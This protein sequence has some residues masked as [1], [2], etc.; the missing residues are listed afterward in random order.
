MG[1]KNRL[2]MYSCR[3]ATRLMAEEAELN[4]FG[5]AKLKMHVFICP[6]C[7]KFQQQMIQLKLQ[8][9]KNL[10]KENTED[11]KLRMK[12]LEDNIVSKI[13]RSAD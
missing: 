6:M 1:E 12:N 11:E 4:W 10:T 13:K 3:E 8:I 5:T 2:L 9:R 7:Q